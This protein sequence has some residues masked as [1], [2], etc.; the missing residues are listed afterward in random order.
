MRSGQLSLLLGVALGLATLPALADVSVPEFNGPVAASDVP[1]A[2]GHNYIFF[3]SNHDLAQHGYVEEEYFARGAANAYTIADPM[4]DGVVASAAQP[5]RTRVVVR[6]PADPKRFNGV[7][8]VEWYNVTNQFDA[9]NVW[10][11]D[12]EHLLREGYVWVGVSA[13]TV[14]VA[15]LKKFNPVRYGELDVGK[16]VAAGAGLPAGPDADALSYDIYSQVGQALKHPTSVDMLHGLKPKLVLAVGESQSA[17]RLSIYVNSINGSA[18][19]YDGF[20]LLSSLGRRIRND[21]PV[22]VMKISTEFDTLNGEAA[23]E[24]PDTDKFRSWEVAGTSHVDQHL[25]ASREPLELRDNGKSLEA[26]MAPLCANPQIG[27]RVPTSYVVAS[28]LDKLVIWAEGG[29]PPP[30]APRLAV[31][32]LNPRPQ[33]A[34]VQ[35]N[36]DGLAQGGI[37]LSELAVPTQINVGDNAPANP[38][39][40]PAGG[41]AIGAGACIRWGYSVDMTFDQLS[42]RYPSHAAYVAEVRKVANQNVKDGFILPFDADAT[43]RAAEASRVGRGP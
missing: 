5:Y 9:E 43:V 1:G 22:P 31:T 4:K 6:R 24:Q 41:E 33:P 34:D 36:A 7:V 3:A 10:F 23:S 29:K 25:R 21:L 32:K 17:N 14:G 11:F 8:V 26:T 12:W 30:G 27:T 28:A 2:P 35:R 20:L 18:R 37:Q 19:V 16:T 40:V 39:G 42:A 13:Q 38:S 15:A